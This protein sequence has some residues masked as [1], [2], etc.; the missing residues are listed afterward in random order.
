MTVKLIMAVDRGNAIGWSDGRLPWRLSLDMKRF[1]S[2]TREHVVV[3]GTNTFYSLNRLEG[4]PQRTNIVIS[5]QHPSVFAGKIGHSVLIYSSLEGVLTAQKRGS[6]GDKDV[7]IIG[8]GQIY[9]EAI[10]KK[11]VEE[12]HLTLVDTS[13][14][15]DV[16]LPYDIS[17]LKRFI[18]QQEKEGVRWDVVEREHVVDN[19]LNTQYVTLVKL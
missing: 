18:L 9:T 7:W 8:G 13:S 19:G 14:G 3:M 5:R 15:A 1:A 11:L 17:A 4:L 2:K 6:F 16:I 10:Q 12:L